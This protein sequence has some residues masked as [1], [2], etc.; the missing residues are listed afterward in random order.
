H[1]DLKPENLILTDEPGLGEHLRILDFGLAKL[2]DGPAMT[3]GLAVGTPSYMSPRQSGPEGA[4]DARPAFYAGA[5]LLSE[6]LGGRK[7]FQSE[8][9]GELLLMHREQP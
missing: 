9:V 1:R 4:S 8:N 5:A 3:A 6:M 7:P 2:R